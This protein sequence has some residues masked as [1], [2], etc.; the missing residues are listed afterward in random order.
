MTVLILVCPKCDSTKVRPIDG[1]YMI[2]KCECG[3]TADASQFN[4]GI[5]QPVNLDADP[6]AEFFMSAVVED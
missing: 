5:G 4:M 2:H 1:T 3:F 6:L